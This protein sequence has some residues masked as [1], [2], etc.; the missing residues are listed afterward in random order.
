MMP[1]FCVLPLIYT[2]VAVSVVNVAVF[3]QTADAPAFEVASVKPNDRGEPG[4]RLDIQPG[5]RFLAI[6]IPLKQLVRAAYTLQLWQIVG[7]PGWMDS[8]RFDITANAGRDIT[9]TTPWT[10]GG[11]FALVQ[12]MLQSLLADRF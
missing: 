11:K 8:D 4:L 3:A 1:R 5:G 6:H 10:P 7:A 2:T 12:L 9:V